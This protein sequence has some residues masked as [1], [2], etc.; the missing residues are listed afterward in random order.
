MSD[1]LWA[2]GAEEIAT[3]VRGGELRAVDVVES[4]LARTASVEPSVAAYL[5]RFD[6][7]ARRHAEEV[8]R[9]RAAG[10]E[11]GPLAGVPVALKDN[12]NLEGDD[13][14]CASRIL[15]GYRAP[16]TA[17]AVERL[18]EAGAIPLG[19]TN[20]DEFAMGSSCENS[21]FQ[22]T[23]NPWRLDAVPG[24]SSG[25]SAAAVAAGSVPLALGSDTGG[26]IR[27]PAAFC[28]VVGLKPTYGRVSR[29]G[30]VAF[31][32]S[33]DQIGPL[34]RSTRDVA[35]CLA[36]IAGADP[37]DATSSRQ[38]VDDYLETI[39]RPVAGMRAGVVA[40]VDASALAPAVRED[41]ERSLDRLREVGVETRTVSLPHLPA[42]IA[43][44]YVIANSEAS[45]NLA[46]FDGI[47]YGRR[48]KSAS[49]L[50]LYLDTREQGFGPEVKRRI[51]LGTFALSSGYYDAYYGKA[52][53]V[54][55]EL[56]RQ[57]S[58][59]F[60]DV[61]LI[62]TPTSPTA[63]FAIG[64]KV[65]DPLSMYLSDI[66]TAPI[67]LAGL[68]ALALPSGNDQGLPLS[69]QLIGRPFAEADLLRVGRAFE[70]ATGAPAMPASLG[71]ATRG[72]SDG[73]ARPTIDR[74]GAPS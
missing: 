44:Y 69:L 48:A 46:R 43:A 28:G 20:L 57:F 53:G 40:E 2:L 12:L 58:A 26:S 55:R 41:W 10:A 27:Q 71:G 1:E 30:L 38:P 36:V 61:D 54:R 68:P 17:T 19:K 18:L 74:S 23:R 37:A 31:A 4:C 3:A 70:R 63:A 60:A 25:G 59:A 39:E 50:D 7:E 52:C 34:A 9:R 33:L 11:L 49:L 5:R 72:S 45:A 64:E 21:A 47:R 66:F 22:T 15:V 13:C 67:N 62:L 6:D 16:Y 42:T 14:T 65:D 56:E 29:Y 73:R 35:L 32:S 8:D 51:L 24:G